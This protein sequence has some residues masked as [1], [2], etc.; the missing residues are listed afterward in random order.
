[1]R[2]YTGEAG[3]EHYH[4]KEIPIHTGYDYNRIVC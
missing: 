3:M 2:K 4:L 1:M